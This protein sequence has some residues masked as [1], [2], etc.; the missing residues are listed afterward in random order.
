MRGWLLSLLWLLLFG[1]AAQAMPSEILFVRHAEKSAERSEDPE[2]SAAGRQRAQQL[3]GVLAEAGL[4][5]IV[6][7]QWRRTR[8]TAA[9]LATRLGLQPQVVATR[10]GVSHTDEVLALL[11]GLEG[12]VLVV[13]HSNTVPEL[14]AV[15]GGPRLALICEGSFGHLLVL[16]P[17]DGSLLRLRYGEPDPPA[18]GDCF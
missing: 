7:T 2:L 3:A 11:R 4:R 5:H 9:P 1:A 17:A 15:L 14:I 16:R 8:D 10:R 18:Q 6:T 12:R 13:G